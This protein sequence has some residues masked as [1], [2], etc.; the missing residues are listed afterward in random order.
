MAARCLLRQGRAGALKTMLQEAQ[1]F[2]GLA[3]TVSLSA[4]SGKSE[5]GQPQNSKKQS[6]PK[7]V[8]E[9]KE[10]GKLLATQTAAELSKNLSSPS[11]YPPAVNKGRKVASPSPSGSVL[12]TDEGVP[13]FLS[14]KTLVEFPQKVLSPFRKQGSDSEA[15]QVGRKVTSPSSSSS[16]SS[17]DS[18]SDDEA[19]VS[20]VTPR[21]VSK[22]RGGLR[23]PEASHSFENRAPRVT[24]SAKEKTLLQK[25]HVDI[26][27][28]E[29]PHQP[30]K[31]GSPAKPSEGRENARPKTTM[32]RSQVDE[33]FLKQSLKE[34]QLQKTFRLNEIDKESQKPF[35]VKGPLPVHTKSG[36]SAPPKG[37]PAPAVLAEEARAEGQLQASPPGAA[38]GHLEKPVPEPQRKAAP[39]LP[40]KETSGTQGIEGHLKRGEAIVEDQI[41]PSNLETVPV[42]NNHGFHEK[43][44]APK[45]EAEG[46]AMEDAAAPGDDRGGTQEPAPV[47]AEPFD[48]TTY[49]NLQ[50]H[51]YST[52]TFL[53]LNLELSKFRMP[54]PSS[55]RE[56]PRH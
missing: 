55:G 27:D 11:S 26:T 37:S 53:D 49:K 42:E 29:K 6:P 33:E 16:S 8:V 2:R 41:P 46:E 20:E 3:P 22:G 54:Q 32:P 9:P 45:L 25:P 1:V 35:E 38:E 4:E 51:D 15:R 30:K 12:F 48:N 24:V 17:S 13:K 50:H 18:E 56:S 28:P 19:D 47:P 39:P 21:V 10:R 43:T 44:A 36:L 31:K 7:N 14:R 23:K 40:R 5:K 34:K 52:Y